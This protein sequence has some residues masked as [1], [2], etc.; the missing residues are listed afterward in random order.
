M[1]VNGQKDLTFLVE[2]A[3]SLYH[4]YLRPCVGQSAHKFFE[5]TRDGGLGAQTMV[6]ARLPKNF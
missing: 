1:Q 4:V 2:L 5:T 6:S 3:V